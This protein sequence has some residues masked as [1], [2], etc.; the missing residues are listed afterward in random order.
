[1]DLGLAGQTA[2]GH[3][4]GYTV[5]V[6]FSGGFE[7]RVESGFVL[8]VDGA[9][10]PITPGRDTDEPFVAALAGRV[11]ARAG[12]DDR[13]TLHISFQDGALMLADADPDFEAW[14]VAGPDGFKVVATP[15]GGLS[16]WPASTGEA[17]IGAGPA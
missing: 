15:G 2:I 3:D 17:G 5:A 16:V 7:V 10:H 11:V 4:F 12:A 6:E 8:H 14:T 13:G 9:D 1:M